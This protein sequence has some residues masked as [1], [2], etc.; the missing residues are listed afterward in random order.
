MFIAG[1]V[2]AL[3]YYFFSKW[4]NFKTTDFDFNIA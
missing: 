3:I 2:T 4:L 1:A